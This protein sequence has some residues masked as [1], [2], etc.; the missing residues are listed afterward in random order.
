[1]QAGSS[2]HQRRALGNTEFPMNLVDAIQAADTRIRPVVRETWL[3]ASPVFSERTGHEVLVKLE[4]LPH[5]GSFKR[6]APTNKI[7]SLTAPAAGVQ[8]VTASSGN[9]GAAVA[10]A[11]R[12]VGGK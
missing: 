6:G 9:H 11:L 3:E 7:L 12:G 5:T 4:N 1:M 2:Y 8:V 10:Y